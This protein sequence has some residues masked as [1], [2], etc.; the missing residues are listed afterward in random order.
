M[1]KLLQVKQKMY[2]LK[3]NLKKLQTFFLSVFICQSYFNNDGA[4]LYLIFQLINKTVTIFFGLPDIISECE[5]KKLSNEK[6][7]SPSTSNKSLSP[8]VKMKNSRIKL[9]FKRSC[10]KQDKAPFTPNNVVSLYIVYELNIESQDLKT[11]FTLEYC[12]FKSVKL[13]KNANPNIYSYSGY[14]IKF[15]SRLIFSILNFDWGKYVVIYEVNIRSNGHVN[16]K[17]KN[18]FN[19]W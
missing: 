7:T 1:K 11:E 8:L 10:L 17:I 4:R 16:N 9:E 2:L 12:L 18:T 3:I 6:F 13:T 15:D 5:S 14:R 19:S